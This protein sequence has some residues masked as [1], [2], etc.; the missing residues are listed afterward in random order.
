MSRYYDDDYED[1]EY[2]DAY[3]EYSDYKFVGSIFNVAGG[4]V[5]SLSI[6]FLAFSPKIEDKSL[7]IALII[8]AGLITVFFLGAARINFAY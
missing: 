1:E 3:K 2:L 7:K 5:I 4:C 6:F 8:V